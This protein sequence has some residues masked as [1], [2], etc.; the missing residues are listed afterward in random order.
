MTVRDALDSLTETQQE[1]LLAR[2]LTSG[3]FTGAHFETLAAEPNTHYTLT[4]GDLLATSTLSVDV[5][6]RA[7]VALLGPLA[8]DVS[9]LLARIH[10]DTDLGSLDEEGFE[11]ELGPSSAAQELWDLLRRNGKD[12]N[13]DPLARWGIGATT[14]SKI[15][16]RKRPHLIPIQDSVLDRVT[17]RGRRN[18]W[19]LWWEALQRRDPRDVDYVVRARRLREAVGRPDLSTL[20]VYDIVLWMHG[21]GESEAC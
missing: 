5:P 17:Q 20:R 3:C 4:A 18:G 16:A 19:R 6:A 9:R 8:G 13:G 15:M 7:S 10:V 2:Y 11:R 1:R 21:K 14:A 12:A